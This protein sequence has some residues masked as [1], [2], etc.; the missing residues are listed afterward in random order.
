MPVGLQVKIGADVTG[1]MGAFQAAA[2]GAG[3]LGE[4]LKLTVAQMHPAAAAGIAVADALV[5]MTKA[6]ATDRDEQEKLN[7]IYKN[8]TGVTSDYNAAID[9]AIEA[10]A[11]KAFSDSEVREGLQSLIT[12]TKN[13]DQANTLLTDAMNLARFAGVDLETASKALAKAHQ[14]ETGALGKLV[15]GLDKSKSAMDQVAEANK[16]AAGAA[17]TYAKSAEGMG[18]QSSDAFGELS[19]TIGEVFLP[20][21]DEILPMLLPIVKMLGQLIKAVLPLLKPAIQIVVGALKIFIGVLEALIDVISRVMGFIGDMVRRVQ[22]AVNFIGSVDL[23]PFSAGGGESAEGMS[24]SGG[25]SRSGGGGGGIT[26][27][28]TGD[29]IAIERSVLTALRTHSRR[30]GIPIAGI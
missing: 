8:A 22:D 14:G 19:E 23:N 2:G 5:G 28:I 12:A 25:S 27:N 30:T 26:I 11:S 4:S 16:L 17:D 6:A 20:I 15:P 7:Q 21:M 1:L 9:A 18:K 24:R 29:P 3:S 13:A 10:G